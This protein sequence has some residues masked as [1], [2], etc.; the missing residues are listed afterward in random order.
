MPELERLVEAFEPDKLH[1]DFRL[2]LT[3]M[4]SRAFPVSVLQGSIKMTNEPPKG[5]KANVRNAFYQLN[6]EVLTSTQK[7]AAFRKLLFGLAFFHAVI[8]ERK[9]FGPLG[10]NRPY[11]FNESDFEISKQ[12]LGMFLDEY[13]AIPFRVL[14]FV[15]SYLHYGGR[16]TDDKDCRTID[17]ILRTYFCPDIIEVADYK[18]TPSGTYFAPDVADTGVHKGFMDYIESLPLNAEPEVFGMHAN[19]NITCELNE[20]DAALD[21]LMTLVP[22]DAGAGKKKG[23]KEGPKVKSRDEMIAENATSILARM[24]PAFDVEAIQMAYPVVY[25]ESMNTVLAQECIR[26]NKLT[27]AV[28]SSL[29]EVGRALKGLTVMSKEL[30]AVGTAL[31]TN[32]VP[33][34]WE[35]KSYPSLKPLASWVS[36]LIERLQFIGK[37]VSDGSPAVFWVS[38]FFFP[39]AVSRQAGFHARRGIA[40]L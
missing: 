39:Q 40:W 3:S 23:D 32:K 8:Q 9:R 34:M 4:P 35:A 30:D 25:H 29:R 22:Q 14:H 37:W 31:A 5:L 11:D 36:D 10:W 1:R 12:Q 21:I 2:W 13:E 18:F 24:P 16:V 26:Y 15:T 17:V 6:D 7:P 27:A 19:A 20:T 38:G 28:K 33:E